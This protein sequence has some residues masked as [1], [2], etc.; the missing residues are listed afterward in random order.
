[1]DGVLVSWKQR[2]NCKAYNIFI[3]LDKLQ[4]YPYKYKAKLYKLICK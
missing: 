3:T 2:N 4:K 1:M